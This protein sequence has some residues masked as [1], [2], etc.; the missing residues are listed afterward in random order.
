MANRLAASRSG[1]KPPQARRSV[2]D[3]RGGRGVGGE[4]ATKKCESTHT[5]SHRETW[6]TASLLLDQAGNRLKRGVQFQIGGVGEGLGVRVQ[7]KSVSRLT[8]SPTERHG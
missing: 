6:L 7:R 2:S 4:G 1:R 8:L 3:R 5:F